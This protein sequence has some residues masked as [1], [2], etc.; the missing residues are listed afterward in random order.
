[1]FYLRFSLF[2]EMGR[3]PVLVAGNERSKAFF[4]DLQRLEQ[5]HVEEDQVQYDN[6]HTL[7]VGLPHHVR[8][9]SASTAS[10]GSG[11]IPKTNRKK[12]TK[13]AR[14]GCLGDPFQPIKAHKT[15]EVSKYQAFPFHKFAWSRDGQWC[16]GVG[17]SGF[18]KPACTSFFDKI[19]D[20]YQNHSLI[21]LF[22]RWKE[23]APPDDENFCVLER[24]KGPRIS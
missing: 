6:A 17:H 12:P 13:S 11:M 9:S 24:E 4:W 21:S 1:M 10:S 15:I 22:H 20:C 2:H 5:M 18:V 14:Y 16:V 7:H 8:E 23:G 19:T 3:H